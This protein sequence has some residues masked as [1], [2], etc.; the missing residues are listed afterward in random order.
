MAYERLDPDWWPTEPSYSAE[1]SS[2]H[3]QKNRPRA[4]GTDSR[5]RVDACCAGRGPARARGVGLL[6]ADLFEAQ[7]REQDVHRR[8]GAPARTREPPSARFEVHLAGRDQE[9]TGTDQHVDADPCL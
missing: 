1:N 6:S 8:R 3:M 9:R 2:T 7:P 5:A 4:A